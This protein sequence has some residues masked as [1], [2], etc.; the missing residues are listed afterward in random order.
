[1][2]KLSR[3]AKLNLENVERSLIQDLSEQQASNLAGGIQRLQEEFQA[4]L[5]VLRGRTTPLLPKALMENQA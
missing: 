1:M 3:S 4:E 5:S 2:K